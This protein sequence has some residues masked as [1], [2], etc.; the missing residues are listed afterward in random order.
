MKKF[1]SIFFVI[2]LMFGIQN[3]SNAI[4]TGHI[5]KQK[6]LNKTTAIQANSTNKSLSNTFDKQMI[7]LAERYTSNFR[8]CEPFH[9][10]NSLDV[11]GFKTFFKFDIDGWQEN[12][13]YYNITGNL[14]RLGKDI[15]EVFN[16]NLPDE[17]ISQIKPQ[18]QCKFTQENLNTLVDWFI[19]K[20]DPN[21]EVSVRN[22]LK[23]N[24]KANN[25][26]NTKISDEEIIQ[27]VSNPQVCT[28]LNK[29]E[30]IRQMTDILYPTEPIKNE[31]TN[32][33][34]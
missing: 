16:I 12:K 20:N 31:T 18:I 22:I 6:E 1:V 14:N 10:S 9:F 27:L 32:T 13:C 29:E 21:D 4:Q 24:L 26:K 15:R 11:F 2:A 7:D 25:K 8:A 23:L 5:E 19:E 28:I 3:I 33:K 17:K 34:N 30:L